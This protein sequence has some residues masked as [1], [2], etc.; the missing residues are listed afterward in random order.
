MLLQGLLEDHGCDADGL[1]I[2]AM[3]LGLPV[4]EV[5]GWCCVCGG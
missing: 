5:R 3:A 2:I 4:L 1:N